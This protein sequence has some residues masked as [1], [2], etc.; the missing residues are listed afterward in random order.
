MTEYLSGHDG[1]RKNTSNYI[2]AQLHFVYLNLVFFIVTIYDIPTV[3]CSARNRINSQQKMPHVDLYNTMS[4]TPTHIVISATKS[5]G[6]CLLDT[7][8]SEVEL[9]VASIRSAITS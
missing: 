6:H 8:N 5:E 9:L 1:Q 4:Q 2:T 3:Q 7:V